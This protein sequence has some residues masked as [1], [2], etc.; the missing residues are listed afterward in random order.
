MMDRPELGT[1]VTC[2]GC[3]ER[4]YDL[5]RAPAICPK[6]GVQQAPEKPRMLMAG[7]V[8]AITSGTLPHLMAGTMAGHDSFIQ[9][10]G[11]PGGNSQ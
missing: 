7:L 2:V 4:F 9:C 5:N 6:C 1:K 11:R 8:P 10:E 3:H